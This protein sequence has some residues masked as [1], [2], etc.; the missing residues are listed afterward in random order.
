MAI[1]GKAYKLSIEKVSRIL[2][3]DYKVLELAC[4]TGII[5]FGIAH[6][7]DSVIAVDISPKMISVAKDKAAKLSINNINFQVGDGYSLH[8]EDNAFDVIL[9][10]NSLHIVKEPNTLLVEAHRL[11]KLN[12]YIITA[13]DCYAEPVPFSTKV[14]ILALKFM[15]TLRLIHFL[16]N[17]SKKDITTL[18]K[19][20]GFIIIEDDILQTT[21]VN[22]Y[23]LG[24]K[25]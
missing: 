7:V 20:N 18:L 8:Y 11:L 13:T 5:S 22:Y 9:L 23:I 10:F 14:L 15:K 1:Y 3:G 6:E 16:H 24:Q 2:K 21:P 17:F 19:E 25:I 12:G 4:G